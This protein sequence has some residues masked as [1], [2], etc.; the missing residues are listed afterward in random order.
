VAAQ[1]TWT[2]ESRLDAVGPVTQAVREFA[3]RVLGDEGA[4]DLE[5]A[6]VEAVTNVIRQ[7]TDP[8]AGAFG[9]RRTPRRRA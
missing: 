1:S 6:V 2:L 5:L 7:A 9:W 8:R 3:L 4:G